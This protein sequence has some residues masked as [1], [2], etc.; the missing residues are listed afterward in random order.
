MLE[1]NSVAPKQVVLA[2]ASGLIGQNLLALAAQYSDSLTVNALYRRPPESFST[3]LHTSN[4]QISVVDWQTPQSWQAQIKGDCLWLCLGTSK[5]A[6]GSYQQVDLALTVEIAK[7]ARAAGVKQ[8][9][10]VSSTMASLR[11]PSRYLRV[12]A[13][14]E[15]ELQQ[16]HFP[17]LVIMRPGPLLGREQYCAS[18]WDEQLSRPFTQLLAK[19]SGRQR[20]PLAANPARQ[21]AKVM[22][23]ET[24]ASS[25]G[26]RHYAPYQINQLAF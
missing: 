11:S 21:V 24:L 15:S 25:P 4:L 19:L 10:V 1:A 13:Q 14:M 5:H 18:R 9:I 23:N 20:S 8:C 22:I 7:Y 12:K 17:S 26:T 3:D 6:K 16:L 2:G